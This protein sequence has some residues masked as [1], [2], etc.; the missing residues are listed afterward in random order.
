MQE[1]ISALMI[2]SG[3]VFVI[4]VV[5]PVYSLSRVTFIDPQVTDFEDISDH[6][7]EVARLVILTLVKVTDVKVITLRFSYIGINKEPSSLKTVVLIVYSDLDVA[8]IV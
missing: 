8:I 5:S 3:S 6:E 4:L 1:Q 2:S 7:D